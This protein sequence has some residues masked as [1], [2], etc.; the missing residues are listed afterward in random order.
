MLNLK[1]ILM[2]F[3]QSFEKL[4]SFNRDLTESI[5]IIYDKND[6][7]KEFQ[8]ILSNIHIE[9]NSSLREMVFK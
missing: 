8:E 9:N 1:N 5:L 7:F 2:N 4:F 3:S 6:D